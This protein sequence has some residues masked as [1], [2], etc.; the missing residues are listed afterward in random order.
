M[1]K[2]PKIESLYEALK[3][4]TLSLVLLKFEHD[5]HIDEL[6]PQSPFELLGGYKPLTQ[7]EIN[8]KASLPNQHLWHQDYI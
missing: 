3:Q 5:M 7:D 8:G 4:T 6:M 1:R 2:I